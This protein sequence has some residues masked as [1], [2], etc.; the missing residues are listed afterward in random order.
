MVTPSTATGRFELH[1]ERVGALPIVNYFCRRAGLDEA[2]AA[3][4]PPMT[5][6][7]AWPQLRCWGWWCAT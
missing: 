3:M 5:A 7:Y 1:T 2:L 6:D 4:C